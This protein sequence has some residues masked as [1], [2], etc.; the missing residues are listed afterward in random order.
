VTKKFGLALNGPGKSGV[1]G[2]S[3]RSIEGLLN[4]KSVNSA[5]ESEK[6]TALILSIAGPD[7]YHLSNGAMFALA[8]RTVNRWK[9]DVTGR[10]SPASENTTMNK[11]NSLTSL[12][13]SL[14]NWQLPIPYVHGHE[15]S[16]M[17]SS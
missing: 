12:E 7:G 2:R 6:I 1:R 4:C 9:L 5:E 11:T 14:F 16:F 15:F 8:G 10:D 17:D 13:V 3:V